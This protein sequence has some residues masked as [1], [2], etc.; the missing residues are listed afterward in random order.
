MRYFYLS[1]AFLIF[2]LQSENG[3]FT[4]TSQVLECLV[5]NS[6]ATTT[7]IKRS[8]PGT[9]TLII[10]Q[11]SQPR[12]LET[13]RFSFLEGLQPAAARSCGRDLSRRLISD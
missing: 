10:N 3:G 8:R 4:E 7:T 13:N 2:L 9:E 6:L 5:L 1:I 12:R 11:P